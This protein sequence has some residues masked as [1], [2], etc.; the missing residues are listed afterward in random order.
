MNDVMLS[1]IDNPYNP[2]TDYDLWLA[3]DI[4]KGYDTQ[5]YLARMTVTSPN[6]SETDQDLAI[7]HAID[8][9]VRENISG[10][11]IKVTNPVPSVVIE[12]DVGST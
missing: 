8:E 7:I 3:Y 2:F 10:I 4:R 6:L 12:D 5:G 11:Y 1:T 9:I